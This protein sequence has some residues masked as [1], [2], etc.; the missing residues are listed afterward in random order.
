MKKPCMPILFLYMLLAAA[1]CLS[2][3]SAYSS[4]NITDSA[5]TS[6]SDSAGTENVSETAAAA[7]ANHQE[8]SVPKSSAG[9]TDGGFSYM[10]TPY[11]IN[12]PMLVPVPQCLMNYESWINSR[13]Y[14][15]YSATSP[16]AFWNESDIK[17]RS[18]MARG[19]D[20]FRQIHIMSCALIP[21][22]L[23]KELDAYHYRHSEDLYHDDYY[24]DIQIY[25]VLVDYWLNEDVEDSFGYWNGNRHELFYTGVD[26]SGNTVIFDIDPNF[27]RRWFVPETGP[28]RMLIFPTTGTQHLTEI[29]LNLRNTNHMAH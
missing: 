12:H 27:E 10:D 7:Q 9:Q 5:A 22:E 17:T 21:I 18:V 14:R 15:D 1:L 29:G 24:H 2:G 20:N 25:M 13:G 6:A 8:A 19:Y 4:H 16:N 26:A 28:D 11:I 3:C 23:S